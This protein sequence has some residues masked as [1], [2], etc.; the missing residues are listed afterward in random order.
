MKIV[1]GIRMVAGKILF[2]PGDGGA[3]AG[4]AGVLYD[5]GGCGFG[6]GVTQQAAEVVALVADEV[7]AEAL[8]TAEAGMAVPVTAWLQ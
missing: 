7:I 1:E 2:D 3:A 5:P 4:D 8:V 6:G